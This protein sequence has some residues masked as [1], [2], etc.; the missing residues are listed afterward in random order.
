MKINLVKINVDNDQ[1]FLLCL[2]QMKSK[3]S[4]SDSNAVLTVKELAEYL[5]LHPTTVYRLLKAGQ[6][7]AFRVGSDWR[8]NREEIDLWL[9]ELEKNPKVLSVLGQPDQTGGPQELCGLTRGEC[10][11]HS[12][13]R[14]RGNARANYSPD[15]K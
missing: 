5:K 8:F 15:V 4:K 7:P 9:N 13:D 3:A 12:S 1:C 11:S 6:V 14:E 2:A 10:K